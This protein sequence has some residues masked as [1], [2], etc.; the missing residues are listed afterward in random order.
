MATCV[1][2]GFVG[3]ASNWLCKVLDIPAD[4]ARSGNYHTESFVVGR[5]NIRGQR[6]NTNRIDCCVT[7]TQ[8]SNTECEVCTEKISSRQIFAV[9]T[10]M[11]QRLHNFHQF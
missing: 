4:S 5:P 2:R 1:R 3:C 7:Q 8:I 6:P 9:R 11:H 10:K